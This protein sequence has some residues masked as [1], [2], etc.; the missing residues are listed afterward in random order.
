MQERSQ[1]PPY[2]ACMTAEEQVAFL[3]DGNAAGK[4]WHDGCHADEQHEE[5]YA[6][7]VSSRLLQDALVAAEF[8]GHARR[9]APHCNTAVDTLQSR[10]TTASGAQGWRL[11]AEAP[12]REQHLDEQ[13]HVGRPA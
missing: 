8:R 6:E 1:Q 4:L 7:E 10:H 3:T 9:K 5:G 2:A 11:A 13:C 12:L